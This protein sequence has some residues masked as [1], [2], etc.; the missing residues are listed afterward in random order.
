MNPLYQLKEN[1]TTIRT[2]NCEVLL[3]VKMQTERCSKCT[4]FR[5]TLSVNHLR[6]P[7][8]ISNAVK[9]KKKQLIY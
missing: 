5:K 8:V 1:L 7:T 9:K 4:H 2:N 6:I 3:S